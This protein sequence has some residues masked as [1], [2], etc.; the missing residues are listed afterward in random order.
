MPAARVPPVSQVASKWARRAAS[1]GAEYELGVT[2]AGTRWQAATLAAENNYKT[3]VAA[4]AGAGRFGKGVARAGG[5]KYESGATKKGPGRFA[6][7]VGV[8][9]PDYSS[10]VA[11]YLQAIAATDL[12]ARQPAGSE[13]N[14]QR[15][16]AIARALRALKLSR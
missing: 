13:G 8:A 5:T 16:A 15:V 4:A 9:E 14:I 6:Q 2:G 7:G 10:Q 3:A 11:P 12:P 1:A